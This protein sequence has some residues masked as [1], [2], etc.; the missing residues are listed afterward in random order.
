MLLREPELLPCLGLVVWIEYFG[1]VFRTDLL[2]YR[3]IVVAD[4][5][6]IEIEGLRGFR[7]PQA[8]PV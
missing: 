7:F 6:G 4:V 3:T 5:E 8:Q 2:V 1:N